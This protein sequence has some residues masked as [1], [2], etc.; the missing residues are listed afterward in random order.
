[1]DGRIEIVFID[2]GNTLRVVHLDPVYQQRARE[3]V[4]ELSGAKEPAAAFCALL[5]QRYKAYRKWAFEN[6]REASERELWTEWLLPD[7]PRDQV[8][9]RAGELT[10]TYRQTM[11][12]RA[13]RP[14]ARR[15]VEGLIARGYRL[16][17]LSNTITEQEIPEWLEQD[18]LRQH[19]D[20]IVLSAVVGLRKPGAAIYEFAAREARVVPAGCAYVGDNPIRDVKGAREAGWGGVVILL[21][22]E[23]GDSVALDDQYPPDAVIREFGEVLDLFPA[24]T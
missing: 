2:V 19:F 7:R 9:P 17:I 22:S 24:R 4:A 5:D 8:A 14:D 11:G 16:G 3:R 13:A 23:E 6:L 12:R 20:P 21:D 15:V 18:G 1:M 10:F